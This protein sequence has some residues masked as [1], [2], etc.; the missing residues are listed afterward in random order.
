MLIPFPS[1]TVAK[2]TWLG[3]AVEELP[4]GVRAADSLIS[5][6]IQAHR[7]GRS[8]IPLRNKRPHLIGWP[9]NA[10]SNIADLLAYNPPPGVVSARDE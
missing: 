6:T 3:V 10:S 7:L 8:F 4:K 9:V 1:E 2:L 5:A